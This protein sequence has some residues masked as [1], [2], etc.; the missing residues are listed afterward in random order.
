MTRQNGTL[1]AHIVNKQTRVSRALKNA[2]SDRRSVIPFLSMP[3]LYCTISNNVGFVKFVERTLLRALEEERHFA[4][5]EKMPN[6]F[7]KARL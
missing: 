4:L 6:P 2:R 7:A 5:A 3:F 1:F